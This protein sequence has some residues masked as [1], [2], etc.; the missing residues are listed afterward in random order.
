MTVATKTLK[1][2]DEALRHDEGS[3]F[4]Q[5]QAHTLPLCKDAYDPNNDPFRNHLGASVIGRKCSRALWYAFHWVAREPPK[6][7]MMRLWNRGHLE[8]GR[9]LALLQMIGVKVHQHDPATGKQV[10][11]SDHWNYFGGSSDGQLEQ[12]PDVPG[13]RILGEFKTHNDNSYKKLVTDGVV[14]AKYEHFVQMQIYMRKMKLRW[15]LYL[16]V[17]KNDDR[18]HGEIVGLNPDVADRYVERAKEIIVSPVPLRKLNDSPAHYE[19]KWC[20]FR[21]VCHLG[22]QPLKN[23]RTCANVR[24]TGDGKWGCALASNQE[25]PKAIQFTGCPSHEYNNVL[26]RSR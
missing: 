12:V 5:W 14:E 20:E 4:R 16:A 10:R 1:A 21:A 19:C 25:I 17:N 8:E 26:W 13:E 9:M 3:L 23:C 15:A 7:H 18:I 11:I 2:I 6:P 22:A 24:M